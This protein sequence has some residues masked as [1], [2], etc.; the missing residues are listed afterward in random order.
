MSTSDS[1][2]ISHILQGTEVMEVVQAAV[3]RGR[4]G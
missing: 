4:A 1:K 3:T 2:E